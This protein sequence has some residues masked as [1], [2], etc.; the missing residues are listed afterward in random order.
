MTSD[1]SADLPNL[2]LNCLATRIFVLQVLK[3]I[4]VLRNY[5]QCDT[6][7]S[8]GLSFNFTCTPPTWCKAEIRYSLYVGYFQ[9]PYRKVYIFKL[10][11]LFSLLNGSLFT[12]GVD[13]EP[14]SVWPQGY[15]SMDMLE[16]SEWIGWCMW[17]L[18]SGCGGWPDHVHLW[19][20]GSGHGIWTAGP[21]RR[22]SSGQT[23]EAH[24]QSWRNVK[25]FKALTCSPYI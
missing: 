2:S 14:Y 7:C 1:R 8:R 21:W 23:G 19:A 3:Q 18:Q 5:L 11:Q 6:L 24:P 17:F 9:M 20:A 25:D 4:N 22:P 15:C 10:L 16:W 12:K 13:C